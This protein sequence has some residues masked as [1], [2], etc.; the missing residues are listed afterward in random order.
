[1]SLAYDLAPKE[2]IGVTLEAIL[3]A[4][5]LVCQPI[6]SRV[7]SRAELGSGSPSCKRRFYG[8]LPVRT[9]V[10]LLPELSYRNLAS[11]LS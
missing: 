9:A 4:L 11:Q 6:A 3:S 1:M 5:K 7:L 2:G 10:V 8:A